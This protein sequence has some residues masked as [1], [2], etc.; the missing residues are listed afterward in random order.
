VRVDH[1]NPLRQA[2]KAMEP[3][4]LTPREVLAVLYRLKEK[5]KPSG[6]AALS[7]AKGG[8]RARRFWQNKGYFSSNKEM[9]AKSDRK[10][11]AKM[12]HPK[13]KM[14]GATFCGLNLT[15]VPDFFRK[16]SRNPPPGLP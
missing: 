5:P 8:E 4:A 6:R 11:V 10:T 13:R 3:H 9:T 12:A 7:I 1:S 2:L 15:I 16:S 14:N